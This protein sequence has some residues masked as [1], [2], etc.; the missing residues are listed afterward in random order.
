M[1][2]MRCEEI[3]GEYNIS[4]APAAVHRL[5]DALFVPMGHAHKPGIYTAEGPLSRPA[6]YMRGM[7]N[8][9]LPMEADHRTIDLST[10]PWA[11][12]D[13]QYVFLGHLTGHFGHFLFSIASR[14]WALP[15]PLPPNTKLLLL[16]GHHIAE[17]FDLDFAGSI[18][19]SLGLKVSDFV[20]FRDAYRFRELLVPDP[21]IEECLSGRPEFATMCHGIG[22]HLLRSA[23]IQRRDEIIYLSKQRL[24]SG[25]HKVSNEDQFCAAL[26]GHGIRII[27][28]ETL[29]FA[30]QV[31]LWAE[32]DIVTGMCG[33]ALHTSIFVPERR[34][35]GMNIRSWINSCQTILDLLNNNIQRTFYPAEGYREPSNTSNFTHLLEFHDPK[36]TADEFIQQ[37]CEARSTS[38][39]RYV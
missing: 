24:V 28:P 5:Q 3:V 17:I 39:F 11:P 35:L 9:H 22:A 33:S 15:R 12:D 37:I 2:L 29:T 32:H 34:Y 31:R 36:R 30:E 4:E 16:N 25:I 27:S 10:V 8:I 26:E 7:P 23:P 20:T 13:H 21:A 38:E 14:L 18:L 19:S 6:A 1:P